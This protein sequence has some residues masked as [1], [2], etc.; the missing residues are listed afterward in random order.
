[1]EEHIIL[2]IKAF[3]VRFS[4]VRIRI[5]SRF[6]VLTAEPG[7]VYVL[8]D[9]KNTYYNTKISHHEWTDLTSNDMAQLVS[10]KSQIMLDP[11]LDLILVRCLPVSMIQPVI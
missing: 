11:V 6:N 1:M 9:Y 5:H 8:S 4:L 7:L 10:Y 3:L 2:L